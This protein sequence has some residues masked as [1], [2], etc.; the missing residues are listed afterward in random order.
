[1]QFPFQLPTPD[2]LETVKQVE[3]AP[4]CNALGQVK[5]FPDLFP[6][7]YGGPFHPAEGVNLQISDMLNLQLLYAGRQVL[8]ALCLE[9]GYASIASVPFAM[10]GIPGLYNELITF[11]GMLNQLM[12]HAFIF[13]TSMRIWDRFHTVMKVY[14]PW[15]PFT[16]ATGWKLEA[17]RLQGVLQDLHELH[18]SY[19]EAKLRFASM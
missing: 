13:Q 6:C 14:A 17:A 1:M 3:E 2:T 11:T 4:L 9:T 15:C 12:L 10:Q 16:D 5:T 19:Q 18:L 8:T 7:A